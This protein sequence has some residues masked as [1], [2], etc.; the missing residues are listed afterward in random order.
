MPFPHSASFRNNEPGETVTAGDKLDTSLKLENMLLEEFNYA[1]LTAYQAMEDRARISSLYY[2]LIGAVASA[3]A[4]VYQLG[5][6][7]R[8]LSQ[9][10]LVAMLFIAGVISFTFFVKI[11][12]LR[13]AYRE[14]LICM[15]VI[16]EFYF[17]IQTAVPSHS[18]CISLAA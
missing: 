3:L 12:R 4:A 10:I 2:V 15:N 18:A 9:P 6:T 11:I 14:S 13:Q 8:S 1:S 16:K 7:I 5:G 17:A